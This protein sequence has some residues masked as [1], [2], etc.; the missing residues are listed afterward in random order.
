MRLI[1]ADAEVKKLEEIRD[2]AKAEAEIYKKNKERY[3]Y[4]CAANKAANA[5]MR[6]NWL[7]AMP[8]AQIEE[9]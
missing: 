7:N 4:R 9:E 1:D 3:K 6:I 5:Q 8:T 2:K